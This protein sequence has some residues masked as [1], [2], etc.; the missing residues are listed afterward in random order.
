[1]LLDTVGRLNTTLLSVT[2]WYFSRWP[3]I[4]DNAFIHG[5]RLEKAVVG[6]DNGVSEPCDE[7]K[8]FFLN[9]S[10]SAVCSKSWQL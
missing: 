1:M 5:L 10:L 2:L 3:S 6:E 9:Y 4:R 7:L 8:L